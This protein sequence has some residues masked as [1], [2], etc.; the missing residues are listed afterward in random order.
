MALD[1]SRPVVKL[2]GACAVMYFVNN[3]HKTRVCSGR[4]G[5]RRIGPT[6]MCLLAIFSGAWIFSGRKVSAQQPP[7]EY[8]VEAAYLF[9]FLKFVKWP[10]DLPVEMR[11]RWVI[12]IIGDGSF[13]DGLEQLVSGKTVQGREIQVRRFQPKENP[14]GCHILFISASQRKGL[15][16]ILEVMRGS[17]VLLVADM[18]HF[19]ESGGMIQFTTEDSHIRLIINVGAT[20]RARLKVSSKL[21]SLAHSVT[22]V[23]PGENN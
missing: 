12:G 9:N 18:G 6:S 21:L 19:V 2:P 23:E 20:N 14:R 1:D 4:R 15:P 17:S 8:Q 11:T 13:G 7:T 16:R 3:G 5:S 10:D 22:S